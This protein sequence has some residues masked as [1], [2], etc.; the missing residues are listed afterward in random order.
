MT[1]N[2]TQQA[3]SS[4]GQSFQLQ[5]SELIR[6]RIGPGSLGL[7]SADSLV[8][9]PIALD[10]RLGTYGQLPSLS[11]PSGRRAVAPLTHIQLL[12]HGARAHNTLSEYPLD[13]STVTKSMGKRRHGAWRGWDFEPRS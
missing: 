12:R 7:S 13:T 6:Q 11:A 9:R 8:P 3:L 1:C 4:L 10:T 5:T 2:Y